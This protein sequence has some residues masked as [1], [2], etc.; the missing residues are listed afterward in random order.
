M[1]TLPSKKKQQK[2]KNKQP[3]AKE[4]IHRVT[5]FNHHAASKNK[6]KHSWKWFKAPEVKIVIRSLSIFKK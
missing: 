1:E 4:N 3:A 2:K 5:E 6:T